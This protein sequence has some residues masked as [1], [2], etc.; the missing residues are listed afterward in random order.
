MM[1]V[2]SAIAMGIAIILSLVYAGIED[3][4]FYGYGGSVSSF[5]DESM[6]TYLPCD[7]MLMLDS[8]YPTQG[9]VRTSIGTPA[10]QSFIGIFNAVLK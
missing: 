1:S 2:V 9:P 3:A 10:G 8:N 7:C 6:Y 5:W 4:P